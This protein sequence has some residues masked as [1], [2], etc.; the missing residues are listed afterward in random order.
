MTLAHL[1][2]IE[3]GEKKYV[4]SCPVCK[5]KKL[6]QG[7]DDSILQCAHC[8]CVLARE[9]KEREMDYYDPAT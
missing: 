5:G 6:K 1:I 3:C 9:F 2:I 7:V 4:S 8:G